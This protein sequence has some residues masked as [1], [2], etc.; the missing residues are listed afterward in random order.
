V[1]ALVVVTQTAPLIF[2]LPP[3]LGFI[4]GLPEQ[5][6]GQWDPVV[7]QVPTDVSRFYMNRARRQAGNTV[8][9]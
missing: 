6:R 4:I 1:E 5:N 2:I 8:G 3:V 7:A 9:R